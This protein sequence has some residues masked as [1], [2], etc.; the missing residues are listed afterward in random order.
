[1]KRIRFLSIALAVS[2]LGLMTASVWHVGASDCTKTSVGF[3]PLN[4][5]G[6]GLYKNKQ[7][8]LYPNG[9]NLRPALHEIAGVQIAKNIVPLNASGQPDQNGRVALLSIGM[10]N[11]TQEFSTF[12]ALANPDAAKNPKLTIVDGAQGGMSADRIVDLSTTTAQQFWQTV[13]QRLAAAGVT[14][15]QVQVAWVKQADA[16]P[17]LAFPDDALKLKGE[18]ATIAQRGEQ[19]A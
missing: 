14:P 6:A 10:S 7:G 12:I 4:D 18:L 13:D 9:S 16:G 11:T 19:A 8:G 5:L 17:T 15:A 2:F 3:A 1:M